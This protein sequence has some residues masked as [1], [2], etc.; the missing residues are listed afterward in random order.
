M[1]LVIVSQESAAICGRRPTAPREHD[2]HRQRVR[3]PEGE[4]GTPISDSADLSLAL[5]SHS[6]QTV[7]AGMLAVGESGPKGHRC[8]SSDPDHHLEDRGC[9][10]RPPALIR[11]V[12]LTGREL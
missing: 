3:Q 5:L 4:E 7:M 10:P 12:G 8:N 6:R 2:L 11:Q 9:R 1:I